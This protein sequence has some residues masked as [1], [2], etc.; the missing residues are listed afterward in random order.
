M[1]E[2]R[3]M[4]TV[5]FGGYERSAV[6]KRFEFLSTQLFS[7]KN[8]LRETKLLLA[9][10]KKGTDETEA[11]E[12]VLEGERTKLTQVQVQYE[13]A[14]KKIRAAEEDIAARDAEIEKLKEQLA[15]L[16]DEL[17]EKNDRL[18]ALGS[19][20][21]AEALSAVFIEAQ[22]S[23]NLL[24]EM[25][26]RDAS[27]L[28]EN[29]KR[30]A[31]NVITDANNTAQKIV[32]DAETR[33]AEMLTDAEN[34]STQMEAATGNLR[35][36]VLSDVGRL[37][38]EVDALKLV[39]DKFQQDGIDAL[40]EAEKMLTDTEASLKEGGVP[41]F[42][43]PELKEPVLPEEPEYTPVDHSYYAD[44]SPEHISPET[45]QQMNEELKRLQEM[46]D[47]IRKPSD[48]DDSDIQADDSDAEEAEQADSLASEN[49]NEEAGNDSEAAEEQSDSRPDP[50]KT[51]V[52]DLA[53][54]AAQADA[55]SQGRKKYEYPS[56]K[57]RL[58]SESK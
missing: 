18:I 38:R 13:T 31:D 35:A 9:D 33:C 32:F 1:S 55:L 22:K 45:K 25:A 11:V 58:G 24:V 49:D 2:T 54:L 53:A 37:F 6:E 15:S 7:L 27:A 14:S 17:R 39:F 30:L 16:Q 19:A 40:A 43:N 34:R 41:V 52:P 51:I 26:K 23:A 44:P 5:L 42:R 4:Q 47:S 56:R 50:V 36:T 29:S 10:L 20:T 46:A 12:K 48:D 57:K 8:E 21:D 28:E 3:F